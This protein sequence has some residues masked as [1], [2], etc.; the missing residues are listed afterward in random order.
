MKEIKKYLSLT[1]STVTSILSRPEIKGFIAR[2]TSIND[3]REILIVITSKGLEKVK[4]PDK[5]LH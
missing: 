4:K 5:A 2:L 1:A 3:K